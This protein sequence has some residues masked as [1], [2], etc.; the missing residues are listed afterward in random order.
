[1]VQ[2]FDVDEEAATILIRSL[3][4]AWSQP[5]QA[6]LLRGDHGSSVYIVRQLPYS[7][8]LS[9]TDTYSQRPRPPMRHP[10]QGLPLV[11]RHLLS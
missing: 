1:M 7:K 9:D 5:T 10:L 4:M 11:D 8:S 6:T 3:H 2:P